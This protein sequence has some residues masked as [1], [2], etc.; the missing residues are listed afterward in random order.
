[1]VVASSYILT[2]IIIKP[3]K[4]GAMVSNLLTQ[5]TLFVQLYLF[6]LI[7]NDKSRVDYL[8][9]IAGLQA[10]VVPLLLVVWF[11]FNQV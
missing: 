2:V 1:M 3:F 10:I 6:A 9:Y 4:N 7:V 5:T 11:V 8:I